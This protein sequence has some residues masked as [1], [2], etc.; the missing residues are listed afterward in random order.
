MKDH[1]PFIDRYMSSTALKLAFLAAVVVVFISG[2]A[3][4]WNA[5]DLAVWRK[6]QAVEQG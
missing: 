6:D 5:G 4:I 2:C 1:L 3:K